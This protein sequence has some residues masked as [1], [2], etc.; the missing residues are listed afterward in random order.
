[1]SG[2]NGAWH[3]DVTPCWDQVYR[4]APDIIRHVIG[5]AV[6]PG[7]GL[8]PVIAAF[9][10]A[11][12][13]TAAAIYPSLLVAAFGRY[14]NGAYAG[15]IRHGLQLFIDDVQS[16]WEACIDAARAKY[17]GWPEPVDILADTGTGAAPILTADHVP[18]V[19]WAYVSDTAERMGVATS[20]VALAAIVSCA[21]AIS[22]D[23]LVQPKRLDNTWTEQARLWGAIVGPPSILKSPVIAAATAPIVALNMAGHA[24]W[25]AAAREFKTEM[26][27]W[28]KSD[29]SEPAP[30]VPRRAR[31]LV[32]SVTVEALQE[33]LRDD[34]E[35]RQYAPLGK[36]LAR[37]DELGEFLANMDKY[38]T[39][40]GG[41]DRGAW[42]RAYN[43]G[44]Y[45][46]DRIGRGSFITKSWSCCMLGG[47]QPEPIQ[48]IAG[49]AADDGL[50]QRFMFDLPAPSGG[51]LDRAPD[52][53]A[54][55]AYRAI[56]PALAALRPGD[57]VERR[58]VLHREAH[59]AREDINR[60]AE[61]L[62]MM[63]DASSRLQSAFG[64]WPGLFARLCLTFHLI[65]IADARARQEIGPHPAVVS[66]ETARRVQAYMRGILAPM[67]LRA[68]GLMFSTRMA[69]HAG[70]IAGYLLAHQ[71]ERVTARQI[72]KDYSV[73]RP[74]E[75]RR[76]LDET[77]A[78]LELIGWVEA[79]PLANFAKSPTAWKVN[80]R[81]HI[82]FRLRAEA[83]RERRER[84]KEAIA[85]HVQSIR[86]QNAAD[87]ACA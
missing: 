21:S 58:V 20:S 14:P 1:M 46:V 36:V 47:I 12:V 18:A 9:H 32:E 49:N 68:D 41:G 54:F 24:A 75:Q 15:R 70:W 55:A 40:G 50:L 83:E 10:A 7:L 67:L 19:L 77:M 34:A 81:V 53:A 39:G 87:A 65:E 86:R 5:E 30:E 51:G 38:S 84:V 29:K 31:Y 78:M 72:A 56:F 13:E 43:G 45:V 48:K 35:G 57:E 60:L 2:G 11:S 74:P 26:A 59:A 85:A 23:W 69:G 62:A 6:D 52:D 63:P 82:A 76:T 16:C 17:A 80:P 73:L 22:E 42:L 27:E 64:K 8:A 66:A 44:P 28:K 33:V 61:V 79:E 37:Q 3:D 4:V 25:V 71:S